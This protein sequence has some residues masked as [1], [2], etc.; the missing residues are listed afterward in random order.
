[1]MPMVILGGHHCLVTRCRNT[2]RA[3]PRLTEWVAKIVFTP[4]SKALFEIF[5]VGG[6]RARA[7]GINSVRYSTPFRLEDTRR[8]SIQERAH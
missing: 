7:A 6:I 8:S 3:T 2:A 5:T 4:T 1:M